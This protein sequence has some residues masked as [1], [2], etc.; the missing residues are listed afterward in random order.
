MSD[1][2]TIIEIAS[3]VNAS[4]DKVWEYFTQPQHITKW[5]AASADWH[6]PSTTNDLQPGGKFNNRMEAKDGNMGFD[7]EGVYT[8]VVPQK[9]ISYT[10]SDGRLV[11]I[12]FE[13]EGD[14]TNIR[15]DF[16]AE[17]TFSIDQQKS[18]WQ[19]ILDNFAQYTENN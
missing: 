9:Q 16:E 11:N 8:D 14:A 1:Q 18:G 17:N 3:K 4:V 13:S 10:L 12:Y 15:E 19:S 7:F 2:K 6:S 5:N